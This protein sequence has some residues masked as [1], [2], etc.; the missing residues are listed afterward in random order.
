MNY[1]VDILCEKCDEKI[2]VCEN[3]ELME[4]LCILK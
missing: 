3:K 2:N 4:P 1:D